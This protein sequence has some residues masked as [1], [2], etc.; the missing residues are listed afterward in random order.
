MPSTTH[1]GVSYPIPKYSL[2]LVL[3]F[4]N[5][6]LSYSPFNACKTLIKIVNNSK[7]WTTHQNS[8]EKKSQIP[9]YSPLQ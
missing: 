8:E 4:Y 1:N 7:H 5:E 2:Q 6:G 3:E 9:Q